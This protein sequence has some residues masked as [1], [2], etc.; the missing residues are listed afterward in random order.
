LR[1]VGAS[2]C[3]VGR[4]AAG[5]RLCSQDHAGINREDP[6]RRSPGPAPAEERRRLSARPGN[7]RPQTD[8]RT[9]RLAGVSSAG[10]DYQITV[11]FDSNVVFSIKSFHL[12]FADATGAALA[13]SFDQQNFSQPSSA[14]NTTTF[15]YTVTGLIP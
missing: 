5:R 6:Y 2:D 15:T 1:L 4:W 3:H 14:L 8:L 9:A 12:Q 11:P 10:S 7:G 13:N